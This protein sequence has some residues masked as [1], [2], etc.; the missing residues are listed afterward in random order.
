MDERARRW[1]ADGGGVLLHL[2]VRLVRRAVDAP[3]RHGRDSRR[4]HGAGGGGALGCDVAAAR[5]AAWMALLA[6]RWPAHTTRSFAA[7]QTLLFGAGVLLYLLALAVSYVFVVFEASQDAQRRGLQ[8]QVLA[9][10]A[11]LRSLRAQI[12]PHFLFNSLHSI[13]ALTTADPP[14]A[15]RMCLLLGDFLRQTL[16]LGGADRI[17]LSREVALIEKFLAIERVRFGDRLTVALDAGNAGDC[18]V[19]PLLLQPLVENAVTHGIAHLLDGGTRPGRRRARR[20]VAQDR[21]R[22]SVRSGSAQA[23]RAPVW[24]WRTCGHGSARCTASD[25]TLVAEER[26]DRWH[27]ELTLPA[28]GRAGMSGDTLRVVIVDDEPLARTVVREYLKHHAGVEIVAECGNGFDAVK[29]VTELSPDLMFLDVQMPKLNGFE[30][31]EL[32]GRQVPVIFTTAYDQYAL[33][34]FEV[35]AVDYLLKPFSEDR[36]AE[37]LT[38]ARG[39]LQSHEPAAD[40]DGLVADDPPEV[41]AGGAGADP[42]RVAGARD[43]GRED[44]LR[45]GAGRLRVL[46]GGG[47]AV[48]QGSDDGRAGIA[49]RSGAVRA[50]PPVLLPEHRADRAGRALRQG[51]PGRDPPRRHAAAGQPG[52]LRAAREASLG[53]LNPKLQAIRKAPSCNPMTNG[54]NLANPSSLVDSVSLSLNPSPVCADVG[55]WSVGI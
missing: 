39:R 44:R 51:Q 53:S 55:T 37:A 3:R 48:S 19:P 54:A 14:S 34:A 10:E 33:Q 4:R 25:A 35:H 15:R 30:V 42:R 26:G 24:G 46:Q 18:L 40:I 29:A 32:I 22:E 41:R 38:R 2:L 28:A 21:R 20:G 23:R 9:R 36:F 49:A 52:G 16:A 1:R 47:A 50:H 12:D 45:R 27:V 8:G 17:T 11:E 31:L 13:S 6:T 7:I 5:R 43:P